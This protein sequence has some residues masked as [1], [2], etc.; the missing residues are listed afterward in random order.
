MLMEMM[1][2]E[3]NGGL[4]VIIFGRAYLYLSHLMVVTYVI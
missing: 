3:M 1:D 4:M 2:G